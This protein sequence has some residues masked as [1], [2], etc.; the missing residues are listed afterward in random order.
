MI[1]VNVECD[2][3]F[4]LDPPA[5]ANFMNDLAKFVAEKHAVEL[6]KY[7]KYSDVNIRYTERERE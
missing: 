1:I 2:P 5:L 3:Y 7:L 4:A 6:G